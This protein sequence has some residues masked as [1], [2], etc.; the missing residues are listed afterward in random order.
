MS[1]LKRFSLEHYTDDEHSEMVEVHDGEYVRL[2]DVRRE[3]EFILARPDSWCALRDFYQ[4][5]SI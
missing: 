5:N 1:R 2:A 4:A 3:L